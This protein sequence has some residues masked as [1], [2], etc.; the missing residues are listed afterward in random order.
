MVEGALAADLAGTVTI[1]FE[2]DGVRCV[3]EAPL[4]EVA[5]RPDDM[6]LP[7]VGSFQ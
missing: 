6:V 1:H 4:E 3:I 5:A 2:P 7:R